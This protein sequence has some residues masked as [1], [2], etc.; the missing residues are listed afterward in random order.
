MRPN[1]HIA[2]VALVFTASAIPA[3][4]QTIMNQPGGANALAVQGSVAALRGTAH[5][6]EGAEGTYIH[7]DIPGASRTITGF[8][9]FGDESCFPEVKH[10]EGR[11]V[12]IAGVVVL[13]GGAEIVMTDPNQLA[14]V[15]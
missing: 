6:V 3:T 13:D 14:L 8:I 1:L 7:L 10:I 5:V 12:V 4:A 15:G 9:P 11:T 2:L